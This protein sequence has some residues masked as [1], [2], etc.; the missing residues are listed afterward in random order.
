MT[1]LQMYETD[2]IALSIL[3]QWI[4]TS[5]SSLDPLA[6]SLE[7]LHMIQSLPTS[8]GIILSKKQFCDK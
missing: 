2:E 4:N 8:L 1:P 5:W 6:H 7:R 3:I